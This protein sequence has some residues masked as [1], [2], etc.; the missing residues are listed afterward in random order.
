[1]HT[2]IKLGI[3]EDVSVIRATLKDFFEYDTDFE[4]LVIASNAEELLEDSAL[5]SLDQLLC[6]ISLPG[7]SGIELTWIVKNKYP[8]LQIV[9]FTVY[10]EDD[11]IFD[12][13]RAGADGYLLKSSSL[14][15]LRKALLEVREGGSAMSPAIARRVIDFFKPKSTLSASRVESLTEQEKLIVRLILEGNNNRTIADRLFISIDT[16]KYHI[17]KIYKKLQVNSREELERTSPRD[18][19]S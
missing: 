13:L 11:K 6:D 8:D 4:L 19:F 17:K 18:L 5:S 10:E 12:A 1:M 16:I 15:E 2:K 14:I 3:L 9:M 7:K